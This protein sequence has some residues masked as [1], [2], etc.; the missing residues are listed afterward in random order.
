V[1]E[2]GPTP[3]HLC[4]LAVA[5]PSDLSAIERALAGGP[6]ADYVGR[7]AIRGG[8]S[9]LWA[10]G[11]GAVANAVCT[12][13]DGASRLGVMVQQDATLEDLGRLFANRSVVTLVAHWRGP[14]LTKQDLLTDPNVIGGRLAEEQSALP[15]LFRTGL[16]SDWWESLKKASTDAALPSRLAEFLDRRLSQLPPLKSPPPGTSWHMDLITLRHENRAAL[17]EWWPQAFKPGN[18]VELADGL[19]PPEV[20]GAIVPDS[21]MGIADLSN[22]QS[23]QL[24][25]AIKQHRCDR[26]VIANQYETKPLRRLT[27]LT[28]IYDLLSKSAINYADARIALAAKM[29]VAL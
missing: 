18:R 24:V 15:I 17:D 3:P 19:H 25:S 14:Q 27:L 13:V 21:W 22:C 8:A 7:G 9:V 29:R 10:E 4:G 1:A 20:M 16:A 5:L 6:F 23:A 2:Q 12:L 28:V 11:F 26:V